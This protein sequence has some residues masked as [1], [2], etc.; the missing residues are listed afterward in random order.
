M[1]RN[2]PPT[3]AVPRKWERWEPRVF[4]LAVAVWTL[5]SLWAIGYA[6]IG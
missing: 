4:A 1:A 2:R 3:D 5:A 6:F